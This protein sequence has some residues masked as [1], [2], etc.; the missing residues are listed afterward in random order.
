[1]PCIRYCICN[2]WLSRS[3]VA[4][5]S[6]FVRIPTFC[7]ILWHKL[8]ISKSLQIS[9]TNSKMRSDSSNP[10][11]SFLDFFL[12]CPVVTSMGLGGLRNVCVPSMVV[13]MGFVNPP[14]SNSWADIF[15]TGVPEPELHF[16]P[17]PDNCKYK[18]EIVFLF[19]RHLLL[20]YNI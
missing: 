20:F 1:M 18:F 19:L 8:W 13:T 11:T 9:F 2:F 3:F 15:L 6:A 12:I 17:H 10:C 16:D 5:L 7:K 14:L 4:Y